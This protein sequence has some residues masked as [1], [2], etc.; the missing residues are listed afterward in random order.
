[1]DLTL[2]QF[3]AMMPQT[4]EVIAFY[5]AMPPAF[6]ESAVGVNLSNSSWFCTGGESFEGE[7]R[8]ASIMSEARAWGVT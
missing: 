3:V 4:G 7:S 1:M 8:L 5:R 2:E 6:G